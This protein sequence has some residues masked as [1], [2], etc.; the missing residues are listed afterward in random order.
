MLGWQALTTEG[1]LLHA[2]FCSFPFV[3]AVRMRSPTIAHLIG[4]G[5]LLAMK[6]AL[7]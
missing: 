3:A 4:V 2:V 5:G 1:V 6:A 7:E